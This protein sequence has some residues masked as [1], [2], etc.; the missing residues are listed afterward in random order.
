LT[1]LMFR[2]QLLEEDHLPI[3]TSSRYLPDG[4]Q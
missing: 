1:T 4:G 2:Q 3:R